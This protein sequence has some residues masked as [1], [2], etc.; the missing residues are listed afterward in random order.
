[1]A[2][3]PDMD[4]MQIDGVWCPYP[5]TLR[6]EHER[7]KKVWEKKFCEAA[8]E[9]DALNQ[10]TGRL[11][12][13]LEQA[14]AQI[15]VLREQLDVAREHRALESSAVPQRSPHADQEPVPEHPQHLQGRR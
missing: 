9:L 3:K 2:D 5:V 11:R 15:A 8:L 12:V 7:E 14:E 6:K 4:W 13:R 1:M 10:N